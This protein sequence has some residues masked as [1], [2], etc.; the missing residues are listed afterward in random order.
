MRKRSWGRG[1]AVAAVALLAI[2]CRC[3]GTREPNEYPVGDGTYK[4]L[5]DS[6]VND[7][8]MR[9]I[10]GV[11]LM[12]APPQAGLTRRKRPARWRVVMR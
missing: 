12:G 7:I 10:R 5:A 8:Y 11:R 6:G 1:A 3:R 9:L 2:S 4:L